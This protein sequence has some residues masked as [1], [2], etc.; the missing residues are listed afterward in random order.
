MYAALIESVYIVS[1]VLTSAAFT[2]SSSPT[3]SG[4]RLLFAPPTLHLP[5]VAS[6]ASPS[7]F[8]SWSRTHPAPI[9]TSPSNLRRL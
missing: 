6:R 8:A 9:T 7:P 4:Q 5:V 2:A 1:L 3:S